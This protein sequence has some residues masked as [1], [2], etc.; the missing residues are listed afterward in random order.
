MNERRDDLP[1]GVD[2]P[3][4][5]IDRLF[6]G[7]VA[8]GRPEAWELLA[9]SLAAELCEPFAQSLPKGLRESI[10]AAAPSAPLQ[11]QAPPRKWSWIT[12]TGWVTAAA[13]LLAW[14]S[15]GSVSRTKTFA[16]RRSEL[17]GRGADSLRVEWAKSEHPD[18]KSAA[19]DVVWSPGLQEGF[20]RFR[21]LRPN[22]PT[23][24]QYQLWVFDATRDDRYPV[25]GGV[26]DVPAGSEEVIVPIHATLHVEKP[27]LFAVTRERPG[28]V[29]VS[30]R[31]QLVIAAKP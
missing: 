20:M 16:E 4:D 10:L 1:D 14:W 3:A 30:D 26:F 12:A 2:E 22:D 28:G 21:G 27:V 8:E 18:A 25:D 19:G 11:A 24:E 23:K 5:P 13:L 9:G 29:V 17:L 15:F 7:R 31:S 6:D